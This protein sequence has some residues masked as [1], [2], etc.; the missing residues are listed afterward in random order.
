MTIAIETAMTALDRNYDFLHPLFL[1]L[2]VVEEFLSLVTG[3][4]VV[5]S[6][7]GNTIKRDIL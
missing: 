7:T 6:E 5:F 4:P 2:L 3:F 1:G